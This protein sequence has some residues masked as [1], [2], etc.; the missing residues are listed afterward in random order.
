VQGVRAALPLSLLPF[1]PSTRIPPSTKEA[2][3]SL[4]LR[5]AAVVA[6]TF[7]TITSAD[8]PVCT[9]ERL[10]I[11]LVAK[12]PDIVTPTGIA[13]DEQGRVWVIE[14]HTHE[15]PRT[16]NGPP[17]D[18]IRILSD[19]DDKGRAKK[20]TTFADGFKNGMGL[21]LGR[22][23]AVYLVTRSEIYILCDKD[24]DGVADEKKLIVKLESENRYPHNAL[25]G[26][27]FDG[28][29]DVYFTSART[30]AQITS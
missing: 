6:L 10:V 7:P 11:E 15:R 30:M 12:E 21:A 28:L 25:G 14:N 23:G 17:S 13:V 18:R 8:P 2:A 5:L 3:L 26:L 16:Y 1:S 20:I 24:G 19:F 4:A 27:A 9:D 22:D 29:G